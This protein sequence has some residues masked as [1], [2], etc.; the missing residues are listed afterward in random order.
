[1]FSYN[2]ISASQEPGE[3]LVDVLTDAGSHLG[4][5]FFRYIKPIVENWGARYFSY[6]S[7]QMK[8]LENDSNIAK[9]SQGNV[10]KQ[11]LLG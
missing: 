4:I 1:M 10:K 9:E 2:Y 3:V 5:T 11:T 7:K 6:L 8:F